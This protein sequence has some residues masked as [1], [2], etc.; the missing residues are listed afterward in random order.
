[1]VCPSVDL[2]LASWCARTVKQSCTGCRNP[3][4]A[5]HVSC[6]LEPPPAPVEATGP[7]GG[8]GLIQVRSG[9]R[10]GTPAASQVLVLGSKCRYG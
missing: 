2:V 4:S 10:E 1:M 7:V 5:S 3:T 9:N 6:R 8:Q